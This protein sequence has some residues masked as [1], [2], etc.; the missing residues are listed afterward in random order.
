[1]PSFM[2]ASIKQLLRRRRTPNTDRDNTLET[3]PK[4]TFHTGIK[5]LW[6]PDDGTIEYVSP[7]IRKYR[8]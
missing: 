4:K 7:S 2:R 6:N 8:Y 1:M 3:Q 5:P